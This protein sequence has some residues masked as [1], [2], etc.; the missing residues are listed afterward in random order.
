M[1]KKQACE[2]IQ[3]DIISS[4]GDLGLTDNQ[5]DNLCDIVVAH[6]GENSNPKMEIV[7]RSSGFWIVD[8]SGVVDGPFLSIIEAVEAM[9]VSK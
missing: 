5:V 7:E 9:K 3:E 4:Q 8:A 6:L 1:N 2:Q